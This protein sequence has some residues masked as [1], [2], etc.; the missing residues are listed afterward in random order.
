MLNRFKIVDPD[1]FTKML[2]RTQTFLQYIFNT[3]GGFFIAN[4]TYCMSE[5]FEI[6]PPNIQTYFNNTSVTLTTIPLR[7]PSLADAYDDNTWGDLC[8][9]EFIYNKDDIMHKLISKGLRHPKVLEYMGLEKHEWLVE[10]SQKFN[11]LAIMNQILREAIKVCA[12]KAAESQEE[13]DEDADLIL[14][15]TES[16]HNMQPLYSFLDGDSL[17]AIKDQYAR[18]KYQ[19]SAFNT[20]LIDKLIGNQIPMFKQ[21]NLEIRNKI[22]AKSHLRSIIIEKPNHPQVEQYV[23]IK[24]FDKDLILVILNGNLF[25]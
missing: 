10:V 4:K 14:N 20:K 7:L 2:E 19:G 13:S 22:Y 12:F 24:K 18:L 23:E 9:S 15:K 21:F 6:A 5:F 3:F 1:Q 16:H 25:I 17:N 11:M 8:T